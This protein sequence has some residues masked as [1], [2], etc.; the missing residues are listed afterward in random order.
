M[1]QVPQQNEPVEPCFRAEKRR[2][3]IY[4]IMAAQPFFALENTISEASRPV[5]AGTALA[6]YHEEWE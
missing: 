2:H 6:A 1:E 3:R 5:L 4:V